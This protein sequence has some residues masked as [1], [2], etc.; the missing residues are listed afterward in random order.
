MNSTVELLEAEI[1]NLPTPQR[2][3]LF[4]RLLAS[5][6]RDGAWEAAWAKE[7]DQ[8]E[9]SIAAGEAQWLSVA[10]TIEKIRAQLT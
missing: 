2:A 3:L 8:R 1:L 10:E 7:A 4:D 6:D 5:L 9:A